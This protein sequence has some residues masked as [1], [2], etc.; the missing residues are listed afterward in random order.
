M[1]SW[2]PPHTDNCALIVNNSRKVYPYRYIHGISSEAPGCDRSALQRGAVCVWFDGVLRSPCVLWL[3]CASCR[4]WSRCA[5]HSSSY[6]LRPFLRLSVALSLPWIVGKVSAC[7]G[8]GPALCVRCGASV[9]AQSVGGS[10]SGGV[11]RSSVGSCAGHG[12]QAVRCPLSLSAKCP[13]PGLRIISAGLLLFM[14]SRSSPHLPSI[15]IHRA[16]IL[17]SIGPLSIPI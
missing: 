17:S 7:L 13:A 3:L 16:S 1:S 5:V 6:D 11:V 2:C 9:R 12:G 10:W 4:A 14:G 8:V 15:G